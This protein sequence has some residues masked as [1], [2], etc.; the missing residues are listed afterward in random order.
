ML[1]SDVHAL[2][3]STLNAASNV[4]KFAV[5]YCAKEFVSK[6]GGNSF[7]KY[8]FFNKSS[9]DTNFTPL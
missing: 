5:I 1:C 9:N 2:I 6:G 3:F 8:P 7:G 4:D